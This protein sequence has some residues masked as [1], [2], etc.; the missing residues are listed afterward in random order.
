MHFEITIIIAISIIVVST[1]LSFYILKRKREA[2][3]TFIESAL[4]ENIPTNGVEIPIL[5]A[6]SG[7]K[8]FAPIT[9]NGNNFN[10]KLVLYSDHFEYQVLFKK[11]AFYSDIESI[12]NHKSRFFNTLQIKFNNS[13]IFYKAVF[14]NPEVLQKVVDF[15]AERGIYP[16]EKS[17]SYL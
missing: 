17:H 10:P 13:A 15:F 2:A 3:Q 9:F 6:Y 11:C 14:G 12:R 8:A 1:F 7:F 16:D 5:Q 4:L